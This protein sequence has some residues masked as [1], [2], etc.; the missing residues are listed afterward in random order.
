M[1]VTSTMTRLATVWQNFS[2]DDNGQHIETVFKRIPRVIFPAHLPC[3]LIFPRP[4]TY[5]YDPY[6]ENIIAETRIYRCV[7]C[8][9]QATLGNMETG[10]TFVENFFDKVRDYFAARP[11]LEDDNAAEPQDVV[12]QSRPLGDGGYFIFE[13]PSSSD[14]GTD[15]FHATDFQFEVKELVSIIYKD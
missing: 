4:A 5:D 13:Y 11:G 15:F 14:A 7:V 9:S 3:V 12:C 2:V 1:S 10:E 6:G 8:A